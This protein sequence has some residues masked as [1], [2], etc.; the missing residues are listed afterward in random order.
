MA[1]KIWR[2]KGLG[3]PWTKIV[4]TWHLRVPAVYYCFEF[5]IERLQR[6]NGL[7]KSVLGSQTA[8]PLLH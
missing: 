2:K 6:I 5:Q 7:E 4:I 8:H 1:G 3:L